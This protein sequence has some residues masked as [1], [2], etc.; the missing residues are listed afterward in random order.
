MSGCGCQ[1][2]QDCGCHGD[3]LHGYV[4]LGDY[5]GLTDQEYIDRDLAPKNFAQR[6]GW[7]KRAADSVAAEQVDIT[8][9]GCS[10]TTYSG[11]PMA[12]TAL[13]DGSMALGLAAGAGVGSS[14][15]VFGTGALAATGAVSTAFAAATFGLG[16]GVAIF[17]I[18]HAHHA[19]AVSRERSLVCQLGAPANYALQLIEQAVNSGQMT[20]DVA[21]K[22]LDRLYSDFVSKA[23]GGPGGLQWNKCNALC[24][25]AQILQA[26]IDKKKDRYAAMAAAAAPQIVAASRPNV[27]SPAGVPATAS[28]YASFYGQPGPPAAA[29]GASGDWLP[30][31]ALLLAG[32]FFLRSA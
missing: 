8:G 7:L 22:S 1:P 15:G 6:T 31:A 25:L 17:S 4:L 5:L 32:F 12:L 16:V 11:P 10:E 30:I 26:I 23:T 27:T 9:L 19:A 21:S 2:G 14:A 13:K 20:P 3:G 24:V 28:S 29:P 18:I